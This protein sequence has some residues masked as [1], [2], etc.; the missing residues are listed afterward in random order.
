MSRGEGC[1]GIYA[2]TCLEYDQEAIIGLRDSAHSSA[3]GVGGSREG[4]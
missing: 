3:F 1:S 2:A 4:G